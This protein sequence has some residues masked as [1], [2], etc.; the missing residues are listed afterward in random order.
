MPRSKQNPGEQPGFFFTVHTLGAT[1]PT[2]KVTGDTI[3][4]NGLK[5]TFKLSEGSRKRV[6]GFLFHHEIGGYYV[7]YEAAHGL[8]TR[9]LS[10]NLDV[11]V[12]DHVP[13]HESF[14]EVLCKLISV[15]DALQ[16]RLHDFESAIKS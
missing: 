9:R 14:L 15:D 8:Q 2:S 13:V 3:M 7:V 1:L 10:R 16:S 12:I 4:Y 5:V 11:H 6:E